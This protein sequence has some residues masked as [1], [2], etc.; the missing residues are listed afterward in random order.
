[1]KIFTQFNEALIGLNHG[2]KTLRAKQVSAVLPTAVKSE[3]KA[4]AQNSKIRALPEDA[5]KSDPRKLWT[6]SDE[7]NLFQRLAG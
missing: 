2:Q 3:I 5:F 6:D 7:R 1:M 4:A